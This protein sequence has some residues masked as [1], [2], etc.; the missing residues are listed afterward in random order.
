MVPI[1]LVT[2]S[3][4]LVATT[5]SFSLFIFSSLLRRH[6]LPHP[7]AWLRHRGQQTP[8]Q[9]PPSHT[10]FPHFE[11]KSPA[12]KEF[13]HRDRRFVRAPPTCPAGI[14]RLSSVALSF[15]IQ[16]LLHGGGTF[17]VPRGEAILLPSLTPEFFPSRLIH[18]DLTF[19]PTNVSSTLHPSWRPF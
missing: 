5:V 2:A 7:Q 3:F 16:G 4:A 12:Q 13:S 14:L 8:P 11:C 18:E 9:P 19:I 1:A 6:D 17:G 15:E 10:A